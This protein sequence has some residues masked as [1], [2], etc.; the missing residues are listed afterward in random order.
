MSDATF[1]AANPSQNLIVRMAG[2]VFNFL[3]RISEASTIS[4][5]LQAVAEMSDAELNAKGTTRERA[6]QD[7]VRDFRH[8]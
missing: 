8:L 6:V 1:Q 3:T 7:I 2:S 5:R 4:R